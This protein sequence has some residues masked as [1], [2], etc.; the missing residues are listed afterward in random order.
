MF[1]CEKM[2][3]LIGNLCFEFIFQ[4]LFKTATCMDRV[5]LWKIVETYSSSVLNLFLQ[6][7]KAL[8]CVIKYTI[9]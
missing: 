9:S 2:W 3:K 7:L 6:F 8:I 5:Q 4:S 1:N